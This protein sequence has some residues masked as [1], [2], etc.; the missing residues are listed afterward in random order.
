MGK[1]RVKFEL[2]VMESSEQRARD[3]VVG[4]IR[5]DRLADDIISKMTV[6]EIKD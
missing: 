6:T 3:L 4:M 5:S 2:L 1:Y